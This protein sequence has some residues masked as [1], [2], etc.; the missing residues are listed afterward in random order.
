MIKVIDM[1]K[2]LLE[3]VRKAVNSPKR[4]IRIA[5]ANNVDASLELRVKIVSAA[6]DEVIANIRFSAG[7]WDYGYDTSITLSIPRT[8]L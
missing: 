3:M 1:D 5:G 7:I 4:E 8:M 6:D 2:D